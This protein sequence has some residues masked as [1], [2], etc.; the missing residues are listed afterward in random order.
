MSAAHANGFTVLGDLITLA[1]T[2]GTCMTVLTVV[3]A[4]AEVGA[5]VR[6]ASLTSGRALLSAFIADL[7]P[8]ML[9]LGL[10][11]VASCAT[12]NAHFVA[13][14]AL[15]GCYRPAIVLGVVWLALSA[16]GRPALVLL[17][18]REAPGRARLQRAAVLVCPLT[19]IGSA[20]LLFACYL[21]AAQHMEYGSPDWPHL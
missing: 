8:Y 19:A 20:G 16:L 12:T 2:L 7:P 17:M 5:Y 21:V 6:I 18:N 13:D 4:A 14:G 3:A 11:V 9:G 10:V 1:A 15:W